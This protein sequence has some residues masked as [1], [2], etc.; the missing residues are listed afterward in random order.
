M[1]L[2][3][4]SRG[5]PPRGEIGWGLDG[6]PVPPTLRPA[7]HPLSLTKAVIKP[8]PPPQGFQSVPCRGRPGPC[9]PSD[10]EGVLGEGG[11]GTRIRASPAGDGG[12]GPCSPR[13]S[14]DEREERAPLCIIG[15]SSC[16]PRHSLQNG[17][18]QFQSLCQGVCGLGQ[19]TPLGQN[20]GLVSGAKGSR[21]FP[22]ICLSRSFTSKLQVFRQ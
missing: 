21:F 5:L 12:N 15:S 19:I 22:T 1:E 16:T 11:P 2:P 3:S 10:G 17:R 7:A 20:S 8:F 9:P 14:S 6:F 18:S 13:R 4:G